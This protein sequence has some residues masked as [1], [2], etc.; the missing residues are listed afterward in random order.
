MEGFSRMLNESG[1]PPKEDAVAD[2]VEKAPVKTQ[3]A[4]TGVRPGGGGGGKRR[5][6]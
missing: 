2:K 4:S 3:G 1:P 5:K 6:G